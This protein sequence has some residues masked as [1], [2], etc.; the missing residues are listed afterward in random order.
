MKKKDYGNV[1]QSF[2]NIT[3]CDYIDFLIEQVLTKKQIIQLYEK[4]DMEFGKGNRE[5]RIAHEE[6]EIEI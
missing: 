3:E 6:N 2:V 5:W 4:I 1:I